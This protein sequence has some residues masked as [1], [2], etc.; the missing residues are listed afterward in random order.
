[1]MNLRD[2]FLQ[3]TLK[4][5]KKI[6]TRM[7][8]HILNLASANDLW[9]AGGGAFRKNIFGYSGTPSGGNNNLANFLDLSVDY[10]I[11]PKTNFTFYFG[12]S[13]GQSVIKEIYKG[14]KRGSYFYWEL[15]RYF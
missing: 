14:S 3:L 6:T 4:P 7:D 1:M 10:A 8:F 11:N 12:H 5:H 9:Y 2:Y 13:I 15:T